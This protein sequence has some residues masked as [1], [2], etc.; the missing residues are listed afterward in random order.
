MKIHEKILAERK[1]RGWTQGELARRCGVHAVTISRYE[2]GTEPRLGHLISIAHAFGHRLSWFE[3]DEERQANRPTLTLHE[4]RPPYGLQPQTAEALAPYV[5]ML[6]FIY[7]ASEGQWEIIKGNI[8]T[9]YRD[10]RGGKRG[11]RQKVGE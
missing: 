5:R 11:A 1:S 10:L 8:E 6:A 7:G 2:R 9:F 3:E 4:D